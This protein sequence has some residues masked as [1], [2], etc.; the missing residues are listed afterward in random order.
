MQLLAIFVLFC[1]AFLFLTKD[2]VVV[3][4]SCDKKMTCAYLCIHYRCHYECD[5]GFVLQCVYLDLFCCCHYLHTA[6]RSLLCGLHRHHT[7]HPHI[8]HHSKA[9][10]LNHCNV[11]VA[12]TS[13]PSNVTCVFLLSFSGA[14]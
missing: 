7:A 11:A 5:F 2:R 4:I 6:R 13:L 14:L 9:A 8:H 1:F 3:K 10:R 12:T